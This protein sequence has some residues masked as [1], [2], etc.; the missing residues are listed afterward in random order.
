MKNNVKVSV[1]VP[2]FQ[3]KETY[4]RECIESILGQT[5]REIELILVSDGAP[6]ETE[7]ILKEYQMLDERVRVLFQ[8]NEGVSVARNRGLAMCTGKYVTFVDSDDY[9]LGE[10]CQQIYERAEESRLELL[11][12]GSY[13]CYPDRREKYM[14]YTDDILL[15][16]GKRK[17]ELQMK[18]M[19]GKLP[20]YEYPSSRFGS[21]SAC[22]KLYRVDF[23]KEKGLLYPCGLK[24]SEDVNF[25]LR[26]FEAAE[27]IGYLNCHFY[28]YRQLPESATY[29]Y[30]PDGIQVFTDALI[31]MGDFLRENKKS[32][33]FWQVYYMR[34][35]F[36]FLESMDMDY[37]NP[38]NPDSFRKRVKKMRAAVGM[39]PYKDALQKLR[40]TYLTF[41][42]KI[43]VFLMRRKW[44]G[45]LCIFYAAY[46][47]TK[48]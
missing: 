10:M 22:S 24:R 20:F 32:E 4:L 23:L 25:N 31:C 16:T 7:E 27:R 19:V 15:F 28:F 36:C 8:E 43:P 47:K 34:C 44:M 33:L 17:E 38:K 18:A 39:Q 40:G 26:V 11:L 46:R 45:L 6:S 13:K 9:I 3:V 14:P 2:V 41:A 29:R 21:G 1:V 35:V 48:K 12:W 37:L 42:R 5:L 30:R